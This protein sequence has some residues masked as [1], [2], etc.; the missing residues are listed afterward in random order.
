MGRISENAG[1]TSIFL[2]SQFRPLQLFYI[3]PDDLFYCLRG[4]VVRGVQSLVAYDY[5][6][7]LVNT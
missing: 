5:D 1:L 2:N 3:S 7:T 6:V 4:R